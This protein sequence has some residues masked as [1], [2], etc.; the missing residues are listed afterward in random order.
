MLGIQDMLGKAGEENGW[1]HYTLLRFQ[2]SLFWF[3]Y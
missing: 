3:L 1:D 2:F